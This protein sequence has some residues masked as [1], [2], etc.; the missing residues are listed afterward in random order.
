SVR[1]S[2]EGGERGQD[3]CRRAEGHQAA[4]IRV[5][6]ELQHLPAHEH[7]AILR[8]LEPRNL[9]LTIASWSRASSSRR[10]ASSFAPAAVRPS[11]AGP[12]APAGARRS[13]FGCPCP[14]ARQPRI[15]CAPPACAPGHRPPPT[16]GLEP[17]G[18]SPS[19]NLL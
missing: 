12:A 4:E 16:P 11:T 6:A 17:A 18:I 9:R 19:T 15:A 7:R 14:R 1:R 13:R 10:R 5:L 8:F 3:L 2:E